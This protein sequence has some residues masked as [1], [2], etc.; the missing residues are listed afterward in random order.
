MTL[1]EFPAGRGGFL[2][3]PRKGRRGKKSRSLEKGGEGTR[4][5]HFPFRKEKKRGVPKPVR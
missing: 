2:V 4:G 3:L 5:P 1:V